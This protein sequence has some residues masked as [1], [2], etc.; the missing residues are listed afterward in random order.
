MQGKPSSF[1]DVE[2]TGGILTTP[3]RL[4]IGDGAKETPWGT[5]WAAVARST[6]NTETEVDSLGFV[7][8]QR[9]GADKRRQDMAMKIRDNCYFMFC[10]GII[11]DHCYGCFCG[12]DQ[13]GRT[14]HWASFGPNSAALSHVIGSVGDI[15]CQLGMLMIGG[16]FH[17]QD[18][19]GFGKL[20]FALSFIYLAFPNWYY[21]PWYLLL[22]ALGIDTA[23]LNDTFAAP[24]WFILCFIYARWMIHGSY[25]LNKLLSFKWGDKTIVLFSPPIQL[26]VFGM[27]AISYM[28]WGTEL[29][30]LFPEGGF[31]NTICIMP[32]NGEYVQVADSFTGFLRPTLV[33]Q[34]LLVCSWLYLLSFHYSQAIVGE[35]ERLVGQAKGWHLQVITAVAFILFWFLAVYYNNGRSISLDQGAAWVQNQE[36]YIGKGEDFSLNKYILPHLLDGMI[37]T[38]EALLAIVFMSQAPFHMKWFGTST[39][40]AYVNQ[41]AFIWCLFEVDHSMWGLVAYLQDYTKT[42]D[43]GW[44]NVAVF[45]CNIALIFGSLLVYWLCA[46]AFLCWWTMLP[47]STLMIMPQCWARASENCTCDEKMTSEPLE[48]DPLIKN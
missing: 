8:K 15:K 46:A 27:I 6:E 42:H 31:R 20:D 3:S 2:R 22:E 28:G 47:F 10:S 9:K 41:Y 43:Y 4:G 26:L 25:Y 5:M 44:T 7:L 33:W 36:Y 19:P 24:R 1:E 35:V 48:T 34:S 32:M 18:G 23:G 16:F 29:C 11:I 39:L 14:C 30:E 37:Q 38:F 12:S 45:C 13:L 17:Q 40:G 21:L